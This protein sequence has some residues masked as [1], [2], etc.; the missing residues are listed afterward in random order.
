MTFAA[1]DPGGGLMDGA[2][3]DWRAID[4]ATA[5]LT[6]LC[7]ETL[8]GE[9]LCGE[10]LCEETLGAGDGD[11]VPTWTSERVAQAT[12]RVLSANGYAAAATAYV[13]ASN[14]QSRRRGV[15]EAA[16]TSAR[17]DNSEQAA[18]GE[19]P[20]RLSDCPSDPRTV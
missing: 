3:E 19:L 10:T 12:Q 16:M 7:G 1:E 15:L 9:T 13:R 2:Q 20:G 4:L 5:V 18:E 6:G 8:C 14:L 11:D 17:Q